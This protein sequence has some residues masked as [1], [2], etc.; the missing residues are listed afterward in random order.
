MKED[1]VFKKYHEAIKENDEKIQ[2]Y[3]VQDGQPLAN[4]ITELG[5]NLNTVGPLKKIIDVEVYKI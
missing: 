4:I 5:L 1:P 2:K 3:I